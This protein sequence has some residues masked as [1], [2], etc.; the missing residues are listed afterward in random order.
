MCTLAT[1]KAS[2][3]RA[4]MLRLGLLMT[5]VLASNVFI[6]GKLDA[7]TTIH[8]ARWT[9]IDNNKRVLF[10]AN[11]DGSWSSYLENFSDPPHLNAVWSN[12]E[13]FPPTRFLLWGGAADLERFE[14]HNVDEYQRTL[15]LYRPYYNHPVRNILR[16]LELRDSLERAI[17]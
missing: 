7:M 15:V 5:Q 16:Y 14:E 2:R 12:T 3:F 6:L 4:F 11:Y 17:R 9:L 13:N 8:F 10:L 1:V